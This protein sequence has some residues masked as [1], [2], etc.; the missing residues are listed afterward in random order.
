MHSKALTLSE[1]HIFRNIIVRLNIRILINQNHMKHTF[2]I[3]LVFIAFSVHS[4][5]AVQH[6]YYG[7]NEMLGADMYFKI[8]GTEST[9]L[10]GG[11]SGALN[12]NK[13]IGDWMPGK[14]QPYEEQYKTGSTKEQWCSIY[15]IGSLGYINKFLIS[16]NLGLAVY[17]LKTN[18]KGINP[19]TL[20]DYLYNKN[21]K[22]LYEPLYGVNA[23]YQITKDVGLMTGYDNFNGFKFGASIIFE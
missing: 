15:L 11:F 1:I 16:Y 19:S 20:E 5:E 3:L 12:K 2:T 4:Q 9:F 8:R 17:D 13:A 21:E 18:F 6:Y 23:Q 14:M 22:V 7:S 10:G